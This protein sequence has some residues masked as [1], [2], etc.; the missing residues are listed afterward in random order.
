MSWLESR[1]AHQSL[2]ERRWELR[3]GVG[4]QAVTDGGWPKGFRNLN[5][6]MKPRLRTGVPISF[7]K[8]HISPTCM[9]SLGTTLNFSW[10]SQTSSSVYPPPRTII[11]AASLSIYLPGRSGKGCCKILAADRWELVRLILL[12]LLLVCVLTQAGRW[13]LKGFWCQLTMLGMLSW[14]YRPFQAVLPNFLLH[15]C[16]ATELSKTIKESE[17]VCQKYKYIAT[18]R[19]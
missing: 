6:C 7:Q 12:L 13:W 10:A 8:V 1:W 3:T 2:V 17:P 9:V 5:A 19:Y 18:S 15:I 14:Q 4:W 11:V 16:I